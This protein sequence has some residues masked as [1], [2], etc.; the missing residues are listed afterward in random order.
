MAARNLA[1][2]VRCAFDDCHHE[3]RLDY[4]HR[5]RR[6]PLYF[7]CQHCGRPQPYRGSIA[8]QQNQEEEA[9]VR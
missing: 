8:E 5:R 1:R 9:R 3:Q 2:W 6:T 4:A 7:R